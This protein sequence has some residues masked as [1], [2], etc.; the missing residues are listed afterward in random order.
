MYS[1][2]S[3]I[4]LLLCHDAKPNPNNSIITR[5]VENRKEYRLVLVAGFVRLLCLADWPA[6]WLAVFDGSAVA[7]LGGVWPGCECKN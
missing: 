6:R 2:S 4:L 3:I 5:L 7:V 1:S